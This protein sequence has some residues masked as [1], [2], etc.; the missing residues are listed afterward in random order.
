VVVV[1]EETP[2]RPYD[3]GLQ[4]ERT[5][6]A[7]RRTALAV[8][9]AG[10]GAAR[11]TVATVGWPGALLGSASAILGL[12]AYAA[13]A[14]RYRQVQRHLVDT[15]RYPGTGLPQLALTVAGLVCGT[16]LLLYVLAPG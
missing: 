13:S 4:P 7:W 5:L 16:V 11:L 12:A 1:T 2:A 9:V 6:L 14:T 15:D 8:T 10:A 3:P